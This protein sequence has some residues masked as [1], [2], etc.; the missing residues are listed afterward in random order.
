[1]TFPKT[2]PTVVPVKTNPTTPGPASIDYPAARLHDYMTIRFLPAPNY[3]RFR[4][5]KNEAKRSRFSP[6]P[7]ATRPSPLITRHSSLATRHSPLAT[8]PLPL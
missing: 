2:K 1:M 7:L 3:L 4:Q 5:K 8:R 6:S